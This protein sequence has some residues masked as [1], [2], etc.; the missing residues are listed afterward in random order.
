MKTLRKI[1]ILEISCLLSSYYI[2]MIGTNIKYNQY[3]HFFIIAFFI[4]IISTLIL[5]FI[6]MYFIKK[7]NK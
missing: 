3:E 7:Y 1:L 4:G 5:D 6:R 2:L